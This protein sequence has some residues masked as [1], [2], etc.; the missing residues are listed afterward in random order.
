MKPFTKH[1]ITIQPQARLCMQ[2]LNI[3]EEDILTTINEWESGKT[4]ATDPI[5]ANRLAANLELENEI[6]ALYEEQRDFPERDI[7]IV[8]TYST[9]IKTR[10]GKTSIRAN[11]H[12][13]ATQV[14]LATIYSP[15]EPEADRDWLEPMKPPAN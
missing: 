3:T 11:I 2:K 7:T 6:P 10:Q 5:T 8:V 15:T 9:T 13:V 4:N 12:W 14:P 1:T